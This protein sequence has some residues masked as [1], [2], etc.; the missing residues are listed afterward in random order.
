MS[1]LNR[2]MTGPPNS[3]QLLHTQRLHLNRW[4]S[5]HTWGKRSPVQVAGL[6]IPGNTVCLHIQ[7]QQGQRTRRAETGSHIRVAPSCVRRGWYLTG[8]ASPKAAVVR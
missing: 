7:P 4:A 3:A 1:A 2:V 6:R 8:L 5:S